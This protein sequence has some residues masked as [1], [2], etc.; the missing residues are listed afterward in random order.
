MKNNES[1]DGLVAEKYTK[2]FKDELILT[3]I[4]FFVR[5]RLRAAVAHSYSHYVF[6]C[7]TVVFCKYLVSNEEF[8]GKVY[9]YYLSYA[10]NRFICKSSTWCKNTHF[11]DITLVFGQPFYL[12]SFYDLDKKMSSVLM[13]IFTVLAKT[14]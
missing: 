5:Q 2:T 7:P 8:R 4:G 14:K 3:T 9:Q 1:F 6:V 10:N 12:K 11:D 13:D